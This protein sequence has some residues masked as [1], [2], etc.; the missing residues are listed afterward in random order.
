MREEEKKLGYVRS[1]CCLEACGEGWLFTF[2][3][4]RRGRTDMGDG[5][6]DG[7]YEDAGRMRTN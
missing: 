1:L 5:G 6:G 4:L 3:T 2:G 7:I